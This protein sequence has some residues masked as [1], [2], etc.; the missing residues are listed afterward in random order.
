MYA[1]RELTGSLSVVIEMVVYCC[2]CNEHFSFT[3]LHF[4]KVE[5]IEIVSSR[6]WSYCVLGVKMVLGSAEQYKSLDL[7]GVF[8]VVV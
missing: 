2:F 5:M 7:R 8:F 3:V 6:L 4:I 1:L